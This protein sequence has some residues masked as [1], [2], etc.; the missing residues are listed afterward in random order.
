M[1]GEHEQWRPVDGYPYEVSDQGRLRRL[2][3]ASGTR[4]GLVLKSHPDR[5]GYRRVGLRRCGEPQRI[6]LVHRLVLGAFVGPRRPGFWTNHKNGDKADNRLANLEWLTQ[7]ENQIHAY[8]HHLQR[9]GEAHG[10]AKLTERQVLAIRTR[11][12]GAYGQQTAL[13]R[14]YGVSQ[15]L[16]SKIVRGEA[17]T[18][19][20]GPITDSTNTNAGH[21]HGRAR[22]TNRAVRRIR[23]RA[24]QGVL[25]DT[26]A[27][28]YGVT[29]KTVS[30]IARGKR[31]KHVD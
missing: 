2:G 16:I 5:M 7:S 31:W 3:R 4:P 26:L 1:D 6:V 20:G 11:Y 12:T 17:W 25:H 28:D 14:E 19:T 9:A 22:L 8:R 30:A 24:G 27:K 23:E 29:R 21:R 15:N 18:S 13:G 10:G